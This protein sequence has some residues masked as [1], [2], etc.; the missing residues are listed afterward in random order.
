MPGIDKATSR[1]VA[2]IVLLVVA[3]SSLRG[4]LPGAERAPRRGSTD[5]PASLVFV[6]ALLVVSLAIIVVAVITRARDPRAAA[7]GAGALSERFGGAG[8]RLAWRPVLIAAGMLAAWLL[9]VWLL[10]G[11]IAPP[12]IDQPTSGSGSSSSPGT[13]HGAG[14]GGG[15]PP[16][17]SGG[18]DTLGYLAASAAT[19]L[20][21]AVGAAVVAV[22]QRW[23]AANASENPVA[24][25][26]RVQSTLPAAASESLARAAELGLA[27]FG[28]LSREPREA[29]IACYAAMERELANFPETVPQDFDT[30]TEVL[31][32][33]VEHH[34]L[35]AVNAAMLVQLFAEARFS[36]H[37]MTER[38]REVAVRM[39][40]LV[41]AELR[42]VV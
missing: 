13:G 33:A 12:H 40:Q 6:V 31:A 39:L 22:R 29:I 1:V 18:R 24:G 32:R 42:S 4:Y 2:V 37:A 23:R 21:L 27:E 19:M 10:S 9:V 17:H 25:V 30:P 35:Q 41:H 3:A 14:H 38:H 5:S 26:L 11:L 28:D 8:G 36:T 7:P 34:A 15:P 20:L 16:P